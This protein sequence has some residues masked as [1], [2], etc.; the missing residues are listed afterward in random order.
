MPKKHENN[1]EK[2]ES[3]ALALRRIDTE[4][5][6]DFKKTRNKQENMKL[7]R[8]HEQDLDQTYKEYFKDFSQ[9][10]GR[11]SKIKQNSA[12]YDRLKLALQCR[13]NYYDAGVT[14]FS[15]YATVIAIVCTILIGLSTL[16]GEQDNNWIFYPLLLVCVCLL[17]MIFIK[18][19]EY[20]KIEF[21]KTV[22]DIWESQ[23]DSIS[24]FPS[25]QK[26]PKS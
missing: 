24:D 14:M 26:R 15:E 1:V 4:I 23:N 3:V 20:K 18:Y 22:M 17:A 7:K 13:L 8:G 9:L 25:C 12:N 11:L 2:K 19:K 5:Y 6:E 21:Y 10:I 16:L